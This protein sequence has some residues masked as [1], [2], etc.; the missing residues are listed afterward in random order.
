M[1]RSP[2]LSEHGIFDI[3][4]YT[5]F[6]RN[7]DVCLDAFML[8]CRG[9]IKNIL[10]EQFIG[11]GI[12]E[13]CQRLGIDRRQTAF[14]VNQADCIRQDVNQPAMMIFTLAER[15]GCVAESHQRLHPRQKFLHAKRFDEIFI[16]AGMKTAHLVLF[17][18]RLAGTQGN[19]YIFQRR[20]VFDLPADFNTVDI[21]Q[22]DIKKHQ[23]RRIRPGQEE[24]MLAGCRLQN[25]I[26]RLAQTD[27]KQLANFAAVIHHQYQ[28]DFFHFVFRFSEI[29]YTTEPLRPKANKLCS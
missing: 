10:L 5:R 26:S 18:C 15:G 11:T 7:H 17:V 25:L 8:I 29:S 20:V 2:V 13:Q 22:P 12:T 21:R 19:K 14:W 23:I 1:A 9:E 27:C 28:T 24:A 3:A 16:R 4:N 6:Q